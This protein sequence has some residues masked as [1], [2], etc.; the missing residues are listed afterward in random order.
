M[1]VKFQSQTFKV[2]RFC[3]RKKVA[4]KDVGDADMGPLRE[5]LRAVGTD[6]GGQPR[7]ADVEMDT[8]VDREDGNCTSRTGIPGSETGRKPEMILHPLQY[9][10]PPHT[11]PQRS[12]RT[13][14][15][16]LTK[17]VSRLGTPR[18]PDPVR[19][20]DVG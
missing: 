15:P 8:D 4:A 10:Y 16:P 19:W 17:P 11:F 6:L 3:A 9:G 1:T 7:Q 20:N 2:A 5:R 13:P 18:R 14:S 12:I